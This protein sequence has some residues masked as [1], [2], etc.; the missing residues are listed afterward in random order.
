MLLPATEDKLLAKW[1]ELFG[2]SRKGEWEDYGMEQFEEN[3]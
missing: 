1:Q 2:L 3:L